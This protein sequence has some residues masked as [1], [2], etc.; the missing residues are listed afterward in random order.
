MSGSAA[1]TPPPMGGAGAHGVTVTLADPFPPEVE[2]GAP[3]TV[4]IRASCAAGC[5]L[6]GTRVRLL[7]VQQ[8]L[9]EGA[10]DAPLEV[11]APAQVGEW[12][13]EAVADAATVDGIHHRSASLALSARVLP[14][15]TSLA[16]WVAESPVK[17]RPF[18]VNVGA[19]C[20]AGCSLQ[21]QL[22]EILDEAGSKMGEGR[23]GSS[24]HAGTSALYAG[25][26]TLTAP[27]RAG[28]FTCFARFSRAKHALPHE[29]AAASFTFRCLEPPDHTL[30]V[31]VRLE[32]IEARKQGIEV[33]AGPYQA[34]TDEGGVARVGVPKGVHELTFWRVDLEPASMRVDVTGDLAVDL[35]AGPRV[36]VD[37]DAERWG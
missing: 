26:I 29:D 37:E 7:A 16:V 34:Y 5:D 8:I 19:K 10:L 21:G 28:V 30:S 3:V 35:V 9:A 18:T 11:R 25:E 1:D 36:V 4:R 23:L 27:D 32:G 15:A 13:C 24:P 2:A 31:R 22:V 20:A 12:K 6:G 14:H 33:R 17:G